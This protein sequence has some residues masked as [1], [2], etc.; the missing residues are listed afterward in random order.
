MKDWT[1]AI[2]MIVMLSASAVTIAKLAFLA[3]ILP[4]GDFAFYTSAFMAAVFAS[5]L[6]S[7]GSVEGL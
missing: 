1:T 5:S 4:K 7:F 6:I 2:F 3:I